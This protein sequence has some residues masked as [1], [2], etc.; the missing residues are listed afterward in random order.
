V[1]ASRLQAREDGPAPIRFE[2]RAGWAAGVID[3]RIEAD[4]QSSQTIRI[5]ADHVMHSGLAVRQPDTAPITVSGGA[6]INMGGGNEH[7]ISE[8]IGKITVRD[9]ALKLE[10]RGKNRTAPTTL[11]IAELN[12]DAASLVV[13]GGDRF[14]TAGFCKIAEDAAIRSALKGGNGSDGSTSA[15]GT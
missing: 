12:R 10:V 8:S 1:P 6:S 9:N 11:T 3:D 15:A 14:G 7:P 2:D 4:P 5:T 13:V